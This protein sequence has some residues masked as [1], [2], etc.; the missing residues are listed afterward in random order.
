MCNCQVKIQSHSGDVETERPGVLVREEGIR[1]GED[2]PGRPRQQLSGGQA[3][4]LIRTPWPVASH[5]M[6]VSQRGP[7]GQCSQSRDALSQECRIVESLEC[8][9]LLSTH[10][11][12]CLTLS[13]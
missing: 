10:P 6:G 11:L 2:E 4:A 5:V 12:L 1:A 9:A 8:V 7:V 13:P 3:A